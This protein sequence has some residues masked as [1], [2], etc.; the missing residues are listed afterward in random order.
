MGKQKETIRKIQDLFRIRN[1]LVKQCL[2]ECLG[3]LILVLFGCG[4]LAQITLSRGTHGAFLTV[5][6]AFGFAVTL[7]VLVAGQVSGAHLNPAVTFALCLLAREP[8]IKFPL[9]SLAQILGGFLGAGII[10]GLYF[11]AIWLHGNNHLIVMGPNATAGIFATYPSEHLTLINGFFD[12]LIGTAALIVCIL[13]IVD[14]FNNPVPKGVE[15]FTIGFVV[16]VIGLAMGFNCGYAVNPA[17]DF[18]PRLFT[19]LAGW[20]TKVFSAG[21]YW[22]WVPILAPLLGAVLGILVY[23]L[24]VGIHTEPEENH[25]SSAEERIKLANM[26]PK[27]NC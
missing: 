8:W 19:S 24:M 21:N 11:D 18:G 25:S 12:Q 27:E 4:A 7:G 10:F 15:A 5:N 9:F 23:Q 20:G 26:K 1:M 17:R 14:P 16:L 3:T 2:A 6:L 22:F 13:A